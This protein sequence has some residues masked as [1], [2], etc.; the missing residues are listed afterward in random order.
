M[1]VLSEM[2]TMN[3]L[4]MMSILP[5]HQMLK[6]LRLQPLTTYAC[7]QLHQALWIMLSKTF[8]LVRIYKQ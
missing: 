8:I 7:F 1:L 6:S 4:E 5:C 3:N 2:E